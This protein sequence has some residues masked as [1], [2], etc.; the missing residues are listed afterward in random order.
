MSLDQ[1]QQIPGGEEQ[2]WRREMF[3][4]GVVP[5]VYEVY[6]PGEAFSP[7]RLFL[8]T[9]AGASER[10]VTTL[11][12]LES[13][14]KAAEA[15]LAAEQTLR[16][17]TVDEAN[18]STTRAEAA[19]AA[20]AEEKREVSSLT[21]REALRD[22]YELVA[23][24]VDNGVDDEWYGRYNELILQFHELYVGDHLRALDVQEEEG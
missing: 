12:A 13:R 14:L 16:Q 19:E 17:L 20:L 22:W 7:D 21:A 24:C 2:T 4:A 9:G 3:D 1:D 6:Q 15:A 11:N 10:L 5:Q 18:A 8:I 23:N